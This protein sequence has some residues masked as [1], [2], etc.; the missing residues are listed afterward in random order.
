MLNTPHAFSVYT[1]LLTEI[2]RELHREQVVNLRNQHARATRA[3]E[4]SELSAIEESPEVTETP[5]A[6]QMH[7]LPMSS[8][9]STRS[10]FVDINSMLTVCPSGVY[11][12]ANII[13]VLFPA[14]ENALKR[15]DK[16]EVWNCSVKLLVT[17]AKRWALGQRFL[18]GSH[19]IYTELPEKLRANPQE[20]AEVDD[21]LWI[22]MIQWAKLAA[23]QVKRSTK[24]TSQIERTYLTSK[25]DSQKGKSASRVHAHMTA[26]VKGGSYG[27]HQILSRKA[28]YHALP[29]LPLGNL[30]SVVESAYHPGEGRQLTDLQ[31]NVSTF[32][33]RIGLKRNVLK[34]LAAT[35]G[36]AAATTTSTAA[37]SALNLLGGG[38]RIT[39]GS[40][41]TQEMEKLM[42]RARGRLAG[43]PAGG[44]HGGA[45]GLQPGADARTGE[46]HLRVVPD[47]HQAIHGG[48]NKSTLHSN[49]S[50]NGVPT[51][52]S[53]PV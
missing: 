13:N 18:G 46:G 21:F 8:G 7:G 17:V 49:I 47:A 4:L 38:V 43:G 34:L 19:S 29:L 33:N 14:T 45:A 36:G 6:A 51:H 35:E 3:K 12:I 44:R 16:R 15:P 20:Q 23:W 52:A 11:L 25:Y 42:Q 26:A 41:F 27:R 48:G 53:S 37:A 31:H 10:F 40:K 1:S 30:R 28:T 5:A 24:T 2:H 50:S 9:K 32:V 39:A 22:M